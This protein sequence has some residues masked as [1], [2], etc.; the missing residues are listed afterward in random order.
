MSETIKMPGTEIDPRV[1]DTP[2]FQ[3]DPFPIYQQLRDHHPIYH[4]RFHNRWIIS[5]Y[6]DVD[7]AFQDNE[8]YDRRC[9][10]QMDHMIL[11]QGTYL[12]PIF[13]N[14]ATAV[15]IVGFVILW[16]DNLSARSCRISFR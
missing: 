12:D 6:W 5:R 14:T 3:K 13:L 4:D 15:N 7:G 11:D 16:Q 9:T 2:E 1:F 10:N 8:S